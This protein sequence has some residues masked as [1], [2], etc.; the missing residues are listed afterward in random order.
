MGLSTQRSF[1]TKAWNLYVF[2]VFIALVFLLGGG[3]RHD[4][5]SLLILRPLAA[6]A[7]GYGVFMTTRKTLERYN[8]LFA[9]LILTAILLV[10]HLVPLAP[11]VQN[12]L[13]QGEILHEINKTGG[14]SPEPWRPLSLVPPAT[15]NALFSLLIPAA[16]LF[17]LS[18][19]QREQFRPILLL[20]IAIGFVSALLGVLQ[21][22]G[23]IKGPFYLYRITN[24][25]LPVGLF[26]NRN[27]QAVF[28][29]C[30][31]PLLAAYSCSFL[32]AP[33]QLQR[34]K[35]FALGV[36]VILVPMIL[37]TGS[38]AGLI[39]GLL[40]LLSVPFIYHPPNLSVPK[41]RVTHSAA[42]RWFERWGYH[43]FGALLLGV[44]VFGSIWFSRALAVDR[45]TGNDGDIRWGLWTATWNLGAQYMPFGSGAGS[46]VEVFQMAEADSELRYQYVNHA[47]NDLLEVF[48]TT[49][50]P[51][52]LLVAAFCACWVRGIW[53]AWRQPLGG[54]DPIAR[55]G[56]VVTGLFLTASLV[57]YPLRTPSLIAL[58]I[59]GAVMMWPIVKPATPLNGK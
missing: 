57:D 53:N 23:P 11:G 28:L 9:L 5:Q 40:G 18:N 42:R 51:G 45:L 44:I 47:H 33:E 15:L 3:A 48:L 30:M 19:L 58:F 37:M 17:L 39:C 38:R 10:T 41:K 1:P 16:T 21:I 13:P 52:L 26:S 4:L 35:W 46:F 25:G 34:R 24:D 31:F 20:M 2:L 43:V 56:L 12:Q 49:G 7:L 6:L 14:I 50:L 32:K 54:A 36:S 22:L 8:F 29:S 59:I 27:H 55:A